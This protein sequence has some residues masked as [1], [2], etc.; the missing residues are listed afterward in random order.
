MVE[1]IISIPFQWYMEIPLTPYEWRD[2][3]YYVMSTQPKS[4]GQPN[5]FYKS[6]HK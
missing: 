5:Q 6:P 4:I 1:N 3:K 2:M